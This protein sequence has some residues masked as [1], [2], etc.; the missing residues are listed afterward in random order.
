MDWASVTKII[1]AVV[2]VI[3]TGKVLYDITIGKK[4]NLREEYKFAKEFLDDTNKVELHPYTLDKGYQAIAGTYIVNAKEVEYILSL[5]NPIQCL[6]DFV[7]SKT[8]FEE[9]K[10]K[11]N[12]SLIFKKKFKSSFSR[13]WR[14]TVYLMAYFSLA[15]FAFSPFLLIQVVDSSNSNSLLQLIFTLPLGGYSAWISLN[16]YA[17]IKRAEHLINNQSS[18]TQK[19]LLNSSLNSVDITKSV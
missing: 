2:G 17:K 6:K 4:T 3:G 15:L 14:K 9:L 12:L 19:V 10:T 11:G 13:W 16:A 18:H 8:L 7:L 5:V 1:L